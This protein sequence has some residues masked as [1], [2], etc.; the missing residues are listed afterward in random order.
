MGIILYIFN[1]IGVFICLENK[2]NLVIEN[3]C[4]EYEYDMYYCLIKRYIFNVVDEYVYDDVGCQLIWMNIE[5]YYIIEK[6]VNICKEWDINGECIQ[7]DIDI[8][9]FLLDNDKG[10]V[11]EYKYKVVM[12]VIYEYWN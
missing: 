10:K 8:I 1:I 6:M 5:I 3:Y 4:M 2:S 9:I 12:I 11:F 7:V